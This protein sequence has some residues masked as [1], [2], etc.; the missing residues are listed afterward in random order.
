[1]NHDAPGEL[2]EYRLAEK[3]GLRQSDLFLNLSLLYMERHEL[4]AA[5][6]ALTIAT[7]LGPQHGET[8]FN[9]SLAYERAELLPQALREIMASLELEADQPDAQNTLAAVDAERGNYEAARAI[10]AKLVRIDPDYQPARKNLAIVD[11]M[12][13]D[14]ASALRLSRINESSESSR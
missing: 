6:N 13:T 14:G 3:L 2:R 7:K 8:H 12:A 11:L 10:W 5:I 4:R 1:M 9:L